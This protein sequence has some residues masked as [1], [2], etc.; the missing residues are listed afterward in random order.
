M[1]SMG[2]K[3]NLGNTNLLLIKVLD[4]NGGTARPKEEE[5]ILSGADDD[6]GH[7]PAI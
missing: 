7:H 6:Y 3:T 2:D 1:K 5:G 4:S